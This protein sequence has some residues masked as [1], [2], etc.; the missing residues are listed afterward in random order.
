MI[1]KSIKQC[2]KRIEAANNVTIRN[3][4]LK[5]G[6]KNRHTLNITVRLSVTVKDVTVEKNNAEAGAPI[7]VNASSLACEGTLKTV[8][9]GG[10]W[11]ALKCRF[12]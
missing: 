1:L 12:K 5:A 8:A 6:C 3:G 10:S 2:Y 4:T 11:Y 9:S 7:I